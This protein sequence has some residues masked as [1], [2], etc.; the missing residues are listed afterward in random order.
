[1]DEFLKD[2]QLEKETYAIINYFKL[3]KQLEMAE[4]NNCD[5]Y[6]LPEEAFILIGGEE[7]FNRL[8]LDYQDGN[9]DVFT[10]ST[11]NL[12]MK[13]SQNIDV[14][15][16]VTFTKSKVSDKAIRD[17]EILIKFYSEE[18]SIIGN[19]K[20]AAIYDLAC[21]PIPSEMI[22]ELLENKSKTKKIGER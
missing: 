15:N 11:G 5:S 9:I 12:F 21:L 3:L 10:N 6:Y 2:R 17:Y 19:K 22:N 13:L 20:R 18:Y 8:L 16:N 4:T 14:I 1:M 7:T